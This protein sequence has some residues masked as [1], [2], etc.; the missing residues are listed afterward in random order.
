[1]SRMQLILACTRMRRRLSHVVTTSPEDQVRLGMALVLIDQRLAKLNSG[2][3]M[4]GH[5]S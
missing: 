2:S 5:S 4:S 1:M 3:W